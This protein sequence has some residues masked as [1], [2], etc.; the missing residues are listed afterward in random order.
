MP[1]AAAVVDHMEFC[2]MHAFGEAPFP[3]RTSTA[4]AGDAVGARSKAEHRHGI[5]FARADLECAIACALKQARR[6]LPKRR[7]SG[8]D[9]RLG[10]LARK[11]VGQLETSHVRLFQDISPAPAAAGCVR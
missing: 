3:S 4:A 11:V 2:D 10:S 1:L 7:L 9:R 6:A 5:P 8:G